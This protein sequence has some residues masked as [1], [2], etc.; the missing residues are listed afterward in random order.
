MA[1]KVVKP[2]GSRNGQQAG[3]KGF[4]LTKPTAAGHQQHQVSHKEVF[5]THCFSSSTSMT[6]TMAQ[7]AKYPNLLMTQNS[8]TAQD[9]LMRF[10]NYKR[11][12]SWLTANT[13][14]MNFNIDKCARMHIGH[15]N[16]E[17]NCTKVNQQLRS[18]EEK[19]DLGITINHRPQVAETNRKKAVRHQT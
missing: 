17:E 8:V 13:W 2:N 7:S 16:I 11:T 18:T 19:H 14:Q 4:A 1:S 3:A 6:Q 9:T 15:S 12:S 5:W 10:L